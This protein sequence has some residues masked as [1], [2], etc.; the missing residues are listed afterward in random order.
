MIA[1]I[2]KLARHASKNEQL[3]K[4]VRSSVLT[5]IEYQNQTYPIFSFSVGT[6]R[7]DAPVL[8]VTG[9]IHGLERIGAQ[10]AWSLLKTT[11][12]KLIWDKTLQEMFQY[13]RLSV[14]PLV[15]PV[16]YHHSMR[17]NPNGVDLMRN[18]PVQAAEPTPFLLGGHRYSNSLPWFQ[19][20]IGRIEKENE[21]LFSFF[22][23]E[24][25]DSKVVI[26][27]DFHSGFGMKDRIWFPFSY[28]STPF[29]QLAEL[30]SLTQLFEQTHPYHI[31]QIEPQSEGY[32]LSG[33]I[34][35]HLYIEFLKSN[36][37]A[38]FLPLTLEMGSWSWVR[39]NPLQL[40]SKEGVFNPILEHRVKRTYRRHHLLFDF[41]L[42]AI[43]SNET[44][45]KFEGSEDRSTHQTLG[46]RRWYGQ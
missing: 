37:D 29:E 13:I 5:E 4:M 10:L 38:I 23:R 32:L 8:F 40:F 27:L 22:R 28:K 43:R 25:K 45:S 2:E 39:K 15:N 26:G 6:Q 21:A 46:L 31:Y 1:S 3:S 16:G 24:A 42:R 36:C 35:D 34:W 30:H 41:L 33:D 12:D 7:L 11:I 20:Q 14:V 17:C 19:G 44:W 18:S 9:G